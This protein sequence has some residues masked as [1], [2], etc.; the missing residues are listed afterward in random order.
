MGKNLNKFI[1]P[2]MKI[3]LIEVKQKGEYEIFVEYKKANVEPRKYKLSIGSLFDYEQ[4]MSV[5]DLGLCLLN[6][7]IINT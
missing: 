4:C 6:S 7:I 3:L 5:L 1:D 2:I